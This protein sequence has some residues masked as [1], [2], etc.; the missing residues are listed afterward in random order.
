MSKLQVG[1][2]M[3]S[4]RDHCTNYADMLAAMK[5]LQAMGYNTVQ[6]SGHSKDITFA[7]LRRLLDETGMTCHCTHISFEEMEQNIDKVIADHKLIGCEYPGIGGLP[8]QFR[9]P[10]GFLEFAKRATVVADKLA[11]AGLHFIYHNHAFEFTRFPETG[12]TGLEILFEN[13]GANVQ[14]E[15]DLFWVQMGGGSPVD[16]IHKVAGRME[17]VHFKE[18]N[19]VMEN[20]NVMA[21]IGCGNMNWP[22]LIAACDEIGVKYAMIEQDNAVESDSLR[23]MQLSH[24]YLT[25]IGASF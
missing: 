23:C 19:G 9:T 18:M 22:A 3:Y 11:D 10:D 20:R 14:F 15:L 8:Q 4:V 24:D 17:V 13:C 7:D 16:W 1:A 2:Q 12:K 6:F 5:S 25:S 21:P